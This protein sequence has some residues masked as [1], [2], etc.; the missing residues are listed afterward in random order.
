MEK[1]MCQRGYLNDKENDFKKGNKN[2]EEV[3]FMHKWLNSEKLYQSVSNSIHLKPT[4]LRKK[5]ASNTAQFCSLYAENILK[6]EAHTLAAPRFLAKH[7]I[8]APLRAKMLD[9]MI[10]VT[11]SYRFTNKTYFDGIQLMDRYFEAEPTRLT[12]AKLHLIGVQCMLIA[13][14]MN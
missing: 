11:T 6:A 9:W 12:P 13:S 1:N 5:P 10:E 2:R 7:E 3:P 4:F 8:D 14:K